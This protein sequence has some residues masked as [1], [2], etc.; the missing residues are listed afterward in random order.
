MAFHDSEIVYADDE[1][2]GVRHGHTTLVVGDAV[3]PD[4][5]YAERSGKRAGLA[6]P[7]RWQN[8]GG[9]A[10]FGPGFGRRPNRFGTAAARSGRDA[11]TLCRCAS[12]TRAVG[13]LGRVSLG[14]RRWIVDPVRRADRLP[15]VRSKL[16]ELCPLDRIQ[17]R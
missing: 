11:E 14:S 13:A 2:A 5:E 17:V 1:H 3:R 9:M 8:A 12:R 4:N 15:D 7:L 6:T 16:Q 10:C